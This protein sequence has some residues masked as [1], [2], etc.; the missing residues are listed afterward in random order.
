MGNLVGWL[1]ILRARSQNMICLL[2]IWLLKEV[3]AKI[4]MYLKKERSK[5][6]KEKRIT[7]IQQN[8]NIQMILFQIIKIWKNKIY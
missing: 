6:V 1:L 5:D 8:S 7:W 4:L 3:L 2:I